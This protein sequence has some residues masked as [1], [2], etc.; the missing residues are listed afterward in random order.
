MLLRLWQGERPR[1]VL[2]AWDT[3]DVPTYRHTA[4]EAYQS[5]REFDA[6]DTLPRSIGHAAFAIP[7]AVRCRRSGPVVNAV[8]RLADG[9]ELDT[10][11]GWAGHRVQVF[12]ISLEEIF[13]ELFG[14]DS[15]NGSGESDRV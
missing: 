14:P 8:V 13:I 7:G 5:G 12:P 11:R 4:L 9:S 15:H 10:L 3:L 1:A 6:R 2:V